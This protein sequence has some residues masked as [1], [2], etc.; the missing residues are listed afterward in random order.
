MPVAAQ[1]LT[2]HDLRI[3]RDG[4]RVHA[5]AAGTPSARNADS[6]DSTVSNP[7]ASATSSTSGAVAP[8]LSLSAPKSP[9]ARSNPARWASVTQ[10]TVTHPSL[11]P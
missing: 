11:A 2:R 7:T 8:S 4:G 1:Q 9:N 3:V 10:Q 5:P 6:A